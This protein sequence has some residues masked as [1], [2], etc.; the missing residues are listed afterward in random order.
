D[1]IPKAKI[2]WDIVHNFGKDKKPQGNLKN[3]FQSNLKGIETEEVT[4]KGSINEAAILTMENNKNE[5][6]PALLPSSPKFKEGGW[7]CLV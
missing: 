3:N 7:V 5:N 4:R 1:N 2:K 6:E